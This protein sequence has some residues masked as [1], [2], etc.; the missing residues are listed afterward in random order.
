MMDVGAQIAKNE[1]SK[2]LE[3]SE[4]F[5]NAGTSRPEVYF[6]ECS[7]CRSDGGG[8]VERFEM[9]FVGALEI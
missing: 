5:Q 9:V 1:K 7:K 4:D 2:D 6:S 8:R 3:R